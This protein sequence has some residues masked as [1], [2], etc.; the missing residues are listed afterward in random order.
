MKVNEGRFERILRVVVGLFIIS[1]TFWGP[2]SAW[3][4]LGLIP[5]LTGVVGFCPL[6]ALGGRQPC[7]MEP[8]EESAKQTGSPGGSE[9][10]E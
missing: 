10:T 2:K 8:K 5:V 7:K 3:G 1:L 4:W 6:Y 9:K